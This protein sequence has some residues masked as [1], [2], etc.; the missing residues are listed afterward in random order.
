MFGLPEANPFF[1]CGEVHGAICGD[2]DCALPQDVIEV[3]AKTLG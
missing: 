3:A 1:R 2:S